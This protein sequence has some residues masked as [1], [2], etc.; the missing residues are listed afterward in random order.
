MLGQSLKV[1]WLFISSEPDWQTRCWKTPHIN[2]SCSS[3]GRH[4]CASSSSSLL[5]FLISPATGTE[6]DFTQ[7]S[8]APHSLCHPCQPPLE[9]EQ[10]S[11][12]SIQEEETPTLWDVLFQVPHLWTNSLRG[13]QQYFCRL[14]GFPCTVCTGAQVSSLTPQPWLTFLSAVFHIL[15]FTSLLLY[16]PS[17]GFRGR[18]F[19][20]SK[21]HIPKF[22]HI[23]PAA[24]KASPFILNSWEAFL[25]DGISKAL[26]ITPTLRDTLI[27]NN[28]P[29]HQG[30]QIKMDTL[31]MSI[32]TKPTVSCSLR[33][34]KENWGGDII[35]AL[36]NAGM[37]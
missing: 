22:Q 17:N 4:R 33:L 10:D 6:L 36:I 29:L 9:A 35:A 25:G 13:L 16:G 14:V 2:S 37:Q 19:T 3:C 34:R 1:A 20:P 21:K 27:H 11:H 15:A 12:P 31:K 28:C 5:P 30:L 8:K 7:M 23:L 32:L 26:W 18:L 24:P